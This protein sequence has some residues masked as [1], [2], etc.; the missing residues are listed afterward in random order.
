MDRI[1]GGREPVVRELPLAG[2][3]NEPGIPKGCQMARDSGL[4]ELKDLDDIAD[5]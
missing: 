1:T 5:T 3:V 4:W 2:Y